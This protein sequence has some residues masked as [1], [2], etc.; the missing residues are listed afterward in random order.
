MR[1]ARRF[2]DDTLDRLRSQ[3][4]ALG[5]AGYTYD[6]LGRRTAMTVPGQA[7]VSY[8]YDAASRLTS[9]TQ[10]SSL[11]QFAYDAASRRTTLTLPNGVRAQYG[12][13]TASRLTSLTHN[14]GAT[15]LGDLQYTYD[16]AGNRTRVGGSWTRTGLPQPVAAATYNA[17]N[18]QLTFGSQTLTYDFNGNLTGDGTSTYTWT[19]RNQLATISGPVPASFVYDGAGRRMRTTINGMVTDVLYDGVN[20]IQEVS[21]AAAASLLTGLGIDEYFV[22]TDTGGASV[23]LTDALGSTV[24]LTD[25]TGAVQTQYTYEPFGQATTT[26]PASSNLFQYTGRENDGTGLYYYRARYY[27]P[28]L[29]RFV[30]EDPIA[31]TASDP[32]LYVYVRNNPMFWLDPDGLR[33]L[34]P[35]NYPISPDVRRALEH[36]N[37][38]IGA[39]KDV[40]ITGGDRPVSSRLGARGRSTHVQGIA[41]DVVVPGQAH[42]VTTYQ[43]IESGLFGGVGWYE[44]GYRGPEGEG[45]HVHVDLRRVPA[46]W[47]Y[48]REGNYYQPLPPLLPN[49]MAGRKP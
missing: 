29:Q 35:R 46:T 32:N 42:S 47:G 8:A 15:V 21:R 13:D 33:V 3:T 19:A 26:G 36:F 4:T 2:D 14:L 48:D 30:S 18:Q 22:R 11:V 49:P 12:Y 45:P 37:T 17:N 24:A 16:P 25:P 43:A 41:A 44:E 1:G 9:M 20:S 23:L 34:N 7:P 39:D 10:D 40:L 31:F 6:A 28:Q 27:H 5:E 38:Y